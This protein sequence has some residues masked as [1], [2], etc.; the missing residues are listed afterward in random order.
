MVHDPEFRKSLNEAHKQ[1]RLAEESTNRG[2]Q[3]RDL[4]ALES[5]EA[6]LRAKL[7]TE[8][9]VFPT[10]SNLCERLDEQLW[11]AF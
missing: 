7:E 1:S 11:K 2:T 3:E 10:L 5:K 4:D 6:E 9:S 8:R